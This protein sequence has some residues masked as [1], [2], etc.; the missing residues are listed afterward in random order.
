MSRNGTSSKGSAREHKDT[1]RMPFKPSTS[2]PYITHAPPPRGKASELIILIYSQYL[3]GLFSFIRSTCLPVAVATAWSITQSFSTSSF[4][5]VLSFYKFKMLTNCRTT[6]PFQLWTQITWPVLKTWGKNRF[7][8]EIYN[9][10]ILW[11]KI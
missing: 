4:L 9:M 3:F 1:T 10:N 7:S 8:A 5:S 6:Q 2:G 11:R